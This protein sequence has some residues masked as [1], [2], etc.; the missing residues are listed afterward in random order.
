MLAQDTFD[1]GS[2]AGGGIALGLVLVFW[3]AIL[4][5]YLVAWW[6]LFV[7]MGQP[8]WVGIVP[9]LNIY[10]I[11][12]LAGR[13]WWWVLLFLVPC[14]NIIASWFLAADTA[15]LFGKD[16]GWAILLFLLPGIGHLVLAF[17]DSQYVGPREQVI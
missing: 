17:G 16:I 9:F 13:E 2:S 12:K 3:L 7:K 8:G 4:V 5:I 1:T 10:V 6:K 15:K 11:F 14:V